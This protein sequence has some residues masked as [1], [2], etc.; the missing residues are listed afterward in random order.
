M[1]PV[2]L[3]VGTARTDLALRIARAGDSWRGIIEYSTD[4]FDASRVSRM[5]SHFQVLLR[6]ALALPATP[7]SKLALLPEDEMKLVVSTWN[8]T[9]VSFPRHQ[10][11]TSLIEDQVRRTPEAQALVDGTCRLSYRELDARAYSI[12]ASLQARG[13]GSGALVGICLERSWKMV[14]AILGVLRSGAA[15]VPLDPAYPQERLATIVRSSQAAL[16]ISEAAVRE[17]LPQADAVLLM[18]DEDVWQAGPSTDCGPGVPTDLAYVIYTSGSTGVPKGVAITHQNAVAFVTWAKRAFT[19]SELKG[20]LASTSIC[21]DLSIFEMFVP[22]SSGGTVILARNALALAELPAR[23]E[24]T[25]VNT[26]PSAMQELLRAKAVPR[27]VRVI[28]LAGEPLTTDLVEKIYSATAVDK[29]YDLYGPSETTTYSTGSVRRSG[30]PATIGRPLDN[31]Q[32]YVLDPLR[33]PVPIG[34]PGELWI[35]GAG[36]AAGYLHQ[37]QLT[38]DRFVTNP[39]R[40]ETRMYRTG[41]LARWREDGN[42]EYL[43][44]LD[45]QVKI[46]GFRIELGE[47]EATLRRTEGVKDAVVVARQ[48]GAGDQRLV[49]Y[50]VC[51]LPRHDAPEIL[52]AAL[53]TSLPEYMVPTAFVL[54]G[55]LPLTPNGKIDR[56]ALPE[57]RW[58]SSSARQTNVEPRTPV[59]TRLLAIYREVLAAPGI[60]IQDNFF[61]AGGHSLLAIRVVSRI[62]EELKVSLPLFALF[63]SPTV[64]SLAALLESPADGGSQLPVPP[65]ERVPRDRPLPVSFVQERLWF[66][67]QFQPG[68]DAYNVPAAFRLRGRLNVEA[69]GRA[70]Q[71]LVRRHEALRTRFVYRDGSLYQEFLEPEALRLETLKLQD[72][73]EQGVDSWAE[74]QARQPFDLSNGPLVRATLA[75]LGPEEHLL[76]VVMHHTISDGWSVGLFFQELEALYSAFVANQSDYNLPELPVQYADFAQWQRSAM[77]GP[78]LD[79]ELAFWKHSLA[80]APQSTDLPLDRTPDG[81]TVQAGRYVLRLSEELRQAIATFAQKE[82]LTP[83]IILLGALKMTIYRWSGQKDLVTGTVVAGRNRQDLENVL[84]CFMN[85]LPLRY[86][87]RPGTSGGEL[88]ADLRKV[89][90]EAQNHQDCPFEKIVESVNPERKGDQNPLYNVAL[91]L[92]NFPSDMFTGDQLD[93][94]PLPVTVSAPLLDLRLEAEETPAGFVVR[95][96]YK[97]DRF[98]PSTIEALMDSFELAL[99]ALVKEP[100]TGL[101]KVAVSPALLEQ[102]TRARSAANR[103]DLCVVSNFT[104]EPVEEPLRVCAREAGVAVDIHFAGYN[105]VFQ[106]LLAPSGL[107]ASNSRGANIVLLRLQDWTRGGLESNGSSPADTLRRNACEFVDAVRGAASRGPTPYLIYICPAAPEFLSSAENASLVRE[108]EQDVV[109]ALAGVPGLYIFPT[110]RLHELYPVQDYSDPASDE[111]GNVPYTPVFFSALATAI[112][113]HFHALKRPAYKVIALDCDNT[114][115]SG[116]C[117]EDGAAGIRLDSCRVALQEFMLAQQQAGMLLVL[118]TKNNLEDV[119]EVFTKRTDMPLRR[120]HI[121]GW[122]VNWSPKSENLK[123]LAQTL[124]LG[125]DSFIFLDDNP[126]ECAEVEAA[127]PGALTLQLPEDPSQIPGFLHRCWAFDHLKVTEEDR[128]RAEMYRQNQAREA[129]RQEAPSLADFIAGLNLQ[130]SIEDLRPE[131]TSRVAQLTQRTNQFNATTRRR[132]EAEI[133]QLQPHAKILCVSVR[134]RFGDYGLVGVVV[135]HERES[136]LDVDTFLLSCRVLGR[137]VEHRMLAVLGDLAR[138]RKLNWVDVHYVR[139]AKNKPAWDF[140]EN[141][142]APFKQPLNGGYIFRFP[143]GYASEVEFNPQ[144]SEQPSAPSAEKPAPILVENSGPVIPRFSRCRA[145]AQDTADLNA[146]HARLNRSSGA[147]AINSATYVAPR[148]QIERQLCELWQNLLK[149]ERVGITDNFFDL[150]GHSLMAV[151]LFS[152]VG[153]LTGEKLPLVTLFQAPTIEQ[154]AHLLHPNKD[155]NRSLLVPIQPRGSK[156]PLFLVH[157]AGGD[158]LWGYAN[159]AAHLGD[160]Q[161]VYGIKSRGQSGLD[162]FTTLEEMAACYIAEIQSFQQTGPYYLGG[163]CFGGNVAYEMARQLQSMG[164]AVGLVALLDSAPTNAGYETIT[165][166]EPSFAKRFARNL[167]YWLEDFRRLKPEERRRFFTRKLRAL[168]RKVRHKFGSPRAEL[169]DLEDVIDTGH[170]PSSELR[171]WQAHLEALVRHTD[172]PYDGPVTLLRTRGQP[173]LCSL[174]EDFCWRKICPRLDLKQV[175]GSHE[176][177]FMEPHVQ[178]L[179]RQLTA[180]LEEARLRAPNSRPQLSFQP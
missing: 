84:G 105:Q 166:W 146:W 95:C 123:Q 94:V 48:Y 68:S 150:G 106:E 148:T 113:R 20:V 131:Q 168:L 53:R 173:L 39:F 110:A 6:S 126:V 102:A 67:D 9:D 5:V 93:V 152:E 163:Y 52:R 169:V 66:L 80:G 24:V 85:F 130:A 8:D 4:L 34:V 143:A 151:R 176:E 44:R 46:R 58:E 149:V 156:P 100:A 180:C 31:E 167:G 83:F 41:D 14:A 88:L 36:V 72:V 77:R 90:L 12:A 172:Q 154:L 29:L 2:P 137:G 57:P 96:E 132:T 165:W 98:E 153:Q 158:V 138:S 71:A 17:R 108:V 15:Y 161:P 75:S 115:W 141:V 97:Q 118:C 112:A 25:L 109:N 155:T 13:V 86:K 117:G 164:E 92:Q 78:L 10:T 87:L 159:L 101:E 18:L 179:A 136:S 21:F 74:S 60:G 43:G 49:A 19:S 63:D 122:A 128:R 120:E 91:L 129:L 111:L 69:L 35:S 73:T 104:A 145:I 79:Q 42:L 116:V 121:S 27:S 76:A 16:I 103:H 133:E 140:L 33:Q 107:L 26:V 65:L 142:G 144:A 40:P 124:N 32:V 11:L 51:A 89:V 175:P 61:D 135:C 45:H 55:G 1:E 114:L 56:K 30:E 119:E 134:D 81:S 3:D 177:I 178:S 70:Y 23:E 157:G 125:L 7:L 162:E 82:G 139:S 160:E 50:V 38:Q 99:T 54:L 174:K 171:L 22:L 59:E 28:N 127:C 37:P 47:I 147:R 170:F 64:E 62:R